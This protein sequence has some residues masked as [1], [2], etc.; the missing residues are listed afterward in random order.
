MCTASCWHCGE[1]QSRPRHGGCELPST[2]VCHLH[3]SRCRDLAQAIIA[4]LLLSGSARELRSVHE[5]VPRPLTTAIAPRKRT[6]TTRVCGESIVTPQRVHR[7][8]KGRFQESV[9][10]PLRSYLTQTSKC[11]KAQ[12]GE[13]VATVACLQQPIHSQKSRG[14]R[15]GHR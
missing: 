3:C 10:R 9:R 13:S 4:R 15:R 8:P 1:R 2:H 6:R 11:P 5:L 12:S 14:L 7:A